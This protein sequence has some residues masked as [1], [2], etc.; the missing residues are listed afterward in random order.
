MPAKLR[1][2]S[3]APTRPHI[4]RHPSFRFIRWF[5]NTIPTEAQVAMGFEIRQIIIYREAFVVARGADTADDIHIAID[6]IVPQFVE[7]FGVTFILFSAQPHP[8]F[9]N[10]IHAA[11]GVTGDAIKLFD[12]NRI[13]ITGT[14]E[15]GNI[16]HL[17]V[18]MASFIEQPIKVKVFLIV[19]NAI[20]FD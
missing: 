17:A 18:T 16:A 6:H 10:E 5:H 11:N 4:L 12:R 13:L 19:R 14:R 7:C 15:A 2:T 3:N 9:R 20:K 1:Y 8:T